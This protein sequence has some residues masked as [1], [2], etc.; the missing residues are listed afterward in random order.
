MGNCNILPTI[1]PA[2]A[3]DITVDTV[4]PVSL[5]VTLQRPL[6]GWECVDSYTVQLYSNHGLNSTEL[7]KNLVPSYNYTLTFHD[8][9]MCRYNYSITVFA[10]SNLEIGMQR[11][12][13]INANRQSKCYAPYQNIKVMY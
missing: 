3:P 9:D 13:P 7:F 2:S 6:Y 4:G 10:T 11:T 5:N 8:L 1:G 12:I